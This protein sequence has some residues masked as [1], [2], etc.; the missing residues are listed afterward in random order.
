MKT[1]SK[2][3]LLAALASALAFGQNTTP[4]TTLSAA[5]TATTQCIPLT[6][7][8]NAVVQGGIFV[9]LEY[10]T[11][12]ST[13][14]SSTAC[15]PVRRAD[16]S[17]QGVA[18]AH[19]SGAKAWIAYGSNSPIPGANGFNY[20]T[21]FSPYGPAV[22]ANIGFLPAIKVTTGQIWDCPLNP[23]AVSPNTCIWQLISSP[24]TV[25]YGNPLFVSI[26][27]TLSQLQTLNSIPVQI[28]PAQGSGTLIE[29]ESCILDLK[30]GS[31]AF[32]GGGAVTIGL[33]TSTPAVAAAAT[34]AS[35]VFT[36]F[37]ASQSILVAGALAVNANSGT[38]N[39]PLWI[40]AG[41]AD[42]ASGTGATGLLECAYRVHTGF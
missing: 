40:Q 3:T 1:L 16:V 5:V 42:F 24:P 10:M 19:A 22:R 33:G 8:T 27:L 26:P 2:I 37:A 35:T 34:I 29:V 23:T 9:D 18:T 15:V 21:A 14:V 41:T 32:T 7:N 4:S 36:T 20:S 17:P 38:L 39:L 6:S 25:L 11:I 13:P 31:A 12:L 28:L 30:R